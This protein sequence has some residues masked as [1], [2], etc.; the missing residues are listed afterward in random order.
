[1]PALPDQFPRSRTSSPRAGYSTGG[2]VTPLNN[3]TK[4]AGGLGLSAVLLGLV[5]LILGCAGLDAAMDFSPAVVALGIADL[6]LSI[7]A[8]RTSHARSDSS[9]LAAMFLAVLSILGG[10]L[11]MAVWLHWPILFHA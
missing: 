2:S 10:V 8:T 1:M 5:L 11:E 4:V 9:T 3:T 6:V 7:V